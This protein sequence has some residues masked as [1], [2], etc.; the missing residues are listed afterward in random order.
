MTLEQSGFIKRIKIL[1]A[2]NYND[3]FINAE[4]T[5][6]NSTWGAINK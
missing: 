6:Y 3:S 2:N 1:C 4:R 5:K